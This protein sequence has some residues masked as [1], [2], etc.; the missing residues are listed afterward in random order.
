MAIADRLLSNFKKSF[1]E[2]NKF[3]FFIFFVVLSTIFW[4]ITKLSNTYDSKVDLSVNLIDLPVTIVPI[5]EK[6]LELKVDL[7]ASG[8]QLLIYHLFNKKV[9]LSFE[10]ASYNSGTALI[11]LF[12]QRF[13]IEQ[14]LF[15]NATINRVTPNVLKFNYDKLER[16]KVAIRPLLNINF[17]PGFDINEDWNIE[18]DSLWISGPAQLLDTL[19]GLNTLPIKLID[20]NTD[21][22]KKIGFVKTNVLLKLEKKHTIVTACVRKFTEKT[23]SS[24]IN[25]KSLPDSL[26]IKLFP[27]SVA[28]TFSVLLDKA[29]RID[30][31][32]FA[33]S[34]DF[35]T[36]DG[37]G[38]KSL[39]VNIERQPQ[40][41]RKVRWKPM[42]VDYLIRQ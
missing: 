30:S 9:E 24:F 15:D 32:D 21:I 29:E 33:F 42:E 4:V 26:S 38:K 31:K 22:K 8:F 28:V 23:V 16:K 37:G 35:D 19:N 27:Q 25:I 20:V 13:Q 39:I 34:C 40:G 1:P 11:N 7:T 10:N 36:S 3:R 6:N 17:L 5:L 2:K 41:V 18:P 14:Q 12:N